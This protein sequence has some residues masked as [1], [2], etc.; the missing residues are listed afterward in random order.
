M[1]KRTFFNVGLSM[2][3]V[4][5]FMLVSVLIIPMTSDP[6]TYAATSLAVGTGSGSEY[7][8]TV[9]EARTYVDDLTEVK[10][11]S[12][13]VVSNGYKMIY[14]NGQNGEKELQVLLKKNSVSQKDKT[15]S[16]RT[17]NS[18]HIGNSYSFSVGDGAT[19]SQ[20]RGGLFHIGGGG[21]ITTDYVDVEL[22][23]VY[24]EEITRTNTTG[25][26]CLVEYTIPKVINANIGTYS[27]IQRNSGHEYILLKFRA[28]SITRTEQVKD[29]SGKVTGTKQVHDHYAFGIYT[30]ENFYSI[31]SQYFTW[32]KIA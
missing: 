18:S 6:T 15:I 13:N 21:Q 32:Q 22:M 24:N 28:V 25:N 29:N 30:N 20:M 2:V 4:V 17:I 14:V 3:L 23:I 12:F 8:P 27:L 5:F 11:G 7:D 10:N 16:T 9:A 26:G 19:T 1:A 31:E